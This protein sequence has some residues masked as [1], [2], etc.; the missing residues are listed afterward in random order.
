MFVLAVSHLVDETARAGGTH[1]FQSVITVGLV[2]WWS[3]KNC[4]PSAT[5]T[6]D[7]DKNR[8]VCEVAN[9]RVIA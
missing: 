9:G 4:K 6:S 8:T 5:L 1:S 2:W 7:A 3:D